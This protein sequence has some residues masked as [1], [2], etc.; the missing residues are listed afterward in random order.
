[1]DVN[2]MRLFE[3]MRHVDDEVMSLG[4][5]HIDQLVLRYLLVRMDAGS[6]VCGLRSGLSYGRIA[7]DI[8]EKGGAGS[9]KALVTF[10]R[11]DV[12]NC[13]TK[14]VKQG[15]LLRDSSS[16][17]LRVSFVFWTE[18]LASP[19]SA[20]KEV[21][22][23]VSTR[24]VHQDS[25]KSDAYGNKNSEVSTEVST[26]LTT[27]YYIENDEFVMSDEWKP[28]T[29]FV[30]LAEAYGYQ[31]GEGAN[32]RKLMMQGIADVQMYWQSSQG[33]HR[34][35][36]QHGWHKELLRTMQV[37][38]AQSSAGDKVTPIAKAAK[39]YQKKR[40]GSVVRPVPHE[41]KHGEVDG[42]QREYAKLGAPAARTQAGYGYPEW[43]SDLR[44]WRADYLASLA[45]EKKGNV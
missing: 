38:D 15:L 11:K 8:S 12:L 41:S 30:K 23:E 1:M 40:R 44:D 17:K 21:S 45:N 9:R 18:Y 42:W 39:A 25:L 10:T 29:Q 24:L 19:K 33:K 28:T 37:I 20:Q 43:C 13:V 7:L 32:Y 22:T 2:S 36:N 16:Q 14:W 3:L 35:D 27:N 34:R 31:V 5:R 4:N 26:S 6:G